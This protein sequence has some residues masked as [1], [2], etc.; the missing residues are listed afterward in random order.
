M[1][2]NPW[3]PGGTKLVTQLSDIIDKKYLLC[4]FWAKILPFL[5]IF[6][7]DLYEVGLKQY[8]EGASPL[9]NSVSQ[10]IDLFIQV[11]I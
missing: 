7:S 8:V 11:G 6:P 2:G 5:A 4:Q 3:Y 10:V 9:A 1:F